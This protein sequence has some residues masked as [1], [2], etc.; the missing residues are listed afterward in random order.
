MKKLCILLF[1]LLFSAF[2]T[3]ETLYYYSGGRKIEL[4][5]DFSSYSFIR[6][7]KTRAGFTLPEDVKLIK[8][9]GNISIIETSSEN[10]LKTLRKSGNLFPAYRK[11]EGG[12]V[13]VSN[14]IFVKIP[15]RPD[16]ENAGKWCEKHGMKLIRQYKYVPEWYLVSVEENPIKKAAALVDSKTAPQAEPDFF[17]PLQ[18][19]AYIPDDTLFKNQWHLHNDSSNTSVSGNDHAHVAE[20]WEVMMAFKG[21]LGGKGVKLA[22]IDDGF[23]LDHEDMEGQ[24]LEGYD[25]RGK[26]NDPSY[27]NIGWNSDYYDMHGTCCAGVAAAKA[28]NGKGVVGACPNC[29]LIPIRI[30]LT[31]DSSLSSIGIEAFEWAADAGAD[32]MSNSWGPAD[33]YGAE[34][35]S[36]TLKDLVA[37]LATSGRN[38]KGIIILFA[39]GNGEESIDDYDTKDGFANNENVFAIGATNASGKRAYYSDYGKSLDFMAPSCDYSNNG[40]GNL[41]DGIWTIDN[42]GKDG[43]N[44]GKSS[45]G[46]KNGNYTNDFGGTSSACP[47]AAG[48]TGLVLS[49]NPD[50]TRDE[51]YQIYV[52]TSDKV[53]GVSYS[54]GF[55]EKYGY[56]RINACEAVKKALETA[57]K[58][59]SQVTCGSSVVNPDPIDPEP[60][61]PTEPTE[62]TEPTTEPTVEPTTEPAEPVCGNG[63]TDAN[64]IC[65]GNS[66]PCSQLADTP[67]NGTAVCAANCMGWDKSGCYDDEPADDSDTTDT[68]TDDKENCG[69]GFLDEGEQC[70]DG[71]RIDG[72][73]CSKYCMKEDTK[74]KSSGCSLDLF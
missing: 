15:G 74:S 35:M 32:I 18:K 33:G 2:L 30:D 31:S 24:F 48:I 20:A 70:D 25:F 65:D 26:D 9:H 41:I 1:T 60:T 29:K 21:N 3:A 51:V 63:V 61:D 58:D 52:E 13:Y 22:I 54:N 45:L 6:T 56:G 7:S 28:D 39:A 36:Q 55:N 53:G 4:T 19:R 27:E 57:G 50:L 11:K 43:Y 5:E 14:Q 16:I 59:V 44:S 38:G 69:N 71:N 34:D 37:N 49:A 62:P 67:V 46:D 10:T 72:D 66:V 73:G 68:D 8:N 40:Y 17:I 64:E 23:D 12:R 42:T 47:L